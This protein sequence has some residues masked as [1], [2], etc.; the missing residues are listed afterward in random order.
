M[1]SFP[2]ITR[3]VTGHRA[4]GAA[5]VTEVGPLRTV[6]EIPAIPGTAF[7]EVWATHASPVPIDNGADP[8]LGPL[9]LPPPPGGTRLRF[10][11][12]PPDTEDFLKDGARHMGE[13]FSQLGDATA[14]TVREASPHPLMHRT[15]SVDYGVV[16]EGEVTLVVD[17]GEVLLKPGSVVIQRGTNHAWA[18]RSGRPCR[19]LFV[20]LSGTYD[21]DIA[22]SL[23]RR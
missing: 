3:I 13:A 10:V 16:I 15:E 17:E 6:V 9:T 22:A 12:I 11:D 21:P 20:L 18:N 2:H 5:I 8:T 14:S 23:S 4:D 7:H 1:T 19:M